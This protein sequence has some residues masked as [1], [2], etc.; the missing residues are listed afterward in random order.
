M[1]AWF[2]KFISVRKSVFVCVS[3]PKIINNLWCDIDIIQLVNKFYSCYMA[4]T[5]HS[6]SA[7][8]F[9]IANPKYYMSGSENSTHV[10]RMIAGI[11]T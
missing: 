8:S 11:K 3:A 5:I 7:T 9:H 6:S 2:L 10:V 4:T 1:R